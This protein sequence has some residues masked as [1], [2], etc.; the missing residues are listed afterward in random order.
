MDL[1]SY[2]KRIKE[3]RKFFGDKTEVHE[4]PPIFHY[5]SHTYL[6]PILEENGY[7]DVVDFFV[8]NIFKLNRKRPEVK[9]ISYGCGNGE[10]ELEIAKK[11]KIIG[12]HSFNF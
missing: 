7:Q 8:Q 2:M 6:K 9:I 4:L 12:L 5:F 3:E 1:I 10:M 11:L